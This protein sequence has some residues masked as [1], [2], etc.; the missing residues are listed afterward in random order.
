MHVRVLKENEK[1]RFTSEP[2]QAG[3]EI[4]LIG[5]LKLESEDIID[6]FQLS[7]E[8]EKIKEYIDILDE[9]KK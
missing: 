3:N 2:D 1:G 6:I 4:S 5:I 9:R 8:L 7:M